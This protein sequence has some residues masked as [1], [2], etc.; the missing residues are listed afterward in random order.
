MGKV[1]D[2]KQ[3]GEKNMMGKMLKQMTGEELLLMRI[4]NSDDMASHIN[5]ELDHRARMSVKT[6]IIYETIRAT[7]SAP[8]RQAA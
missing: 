6:P 3:K 4:L 5:D 2:F 8:A 1:K 7:I